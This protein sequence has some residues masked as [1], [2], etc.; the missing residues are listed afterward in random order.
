MSSFLEK[1]IELELT[2]QCEMSNFI[3]VLNLLVE[4][5]AFCKECVE[6]VNEDIEIPYSALKSSSDHFVRAFHGNHLF[7]HIAH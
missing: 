3:H 1:H 6:I 4:V 5:D 2:E 7:L